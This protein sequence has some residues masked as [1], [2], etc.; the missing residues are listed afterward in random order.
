[1]KRTLLW[2]VLLLLVGMFAFNWR[3]LG[4]ESTVSDLQQQL[5]PGKLSLAHASLARNCAACHTAISGPEDAKCVACHATNTTILQRQV[6]STCAAVALWRC[7]ACS[8]PWA[9]TC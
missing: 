2:I 8:T 3:W 7:S 6:R 9:T 5:S 1:M 4:S